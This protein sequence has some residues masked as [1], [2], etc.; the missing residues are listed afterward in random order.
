MTQVEFL[1]AI[2]D[3]LKEYGGYTLEGP[4]WAGDV[5]LRRQLDGEEKR[6]KGAGNFA[7]ALRQIMGQD[8]KNNPPPGFL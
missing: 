6:R 2:R 7:A 5:I 3:L 8:G 1:D 4:D